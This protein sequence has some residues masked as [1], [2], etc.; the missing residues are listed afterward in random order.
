MKKL[1]VKTKAAKQSDSN[2]TNWLQLLAKK[3]RGKEKLL[4]ADQLKLKTI[5]LSIEQVF[6]LAVKF[7]VR[8]VI[9]ALCAEGLSPDEAIHHLDTESPDHFLYASTAETIQLLIDCGLTRKGVTWQWQH[10][11]VEQG[12]GE[13]LEMVLRLKPAFQCSFTTLLVAAIVANRP[14]IV[15]VLIKNCE[16]VNQPGTPKGSSPLMEACSEGNLAIVTQLL[17]AGA[18]VNYIASGVGANP[19]ALHLV[20][21]TSFS[22]TEPNRLKILRTLLDAGVNTDLTRRNKPTG[23][24]RGETALSY[25]AAAGLKNVVKVLL[26][27][28]A[29]VNAADANGRTPLVEAVQFRH[30]KIIPILLQ[31]GAD[32]NV[33]CKLGGEPKT[34]AKSVLDFCHPESPEYR[35]VRRA[36][37]GNPELKPHASKGASKLST[38]QSW[39]RIAAWL[40]ENDPERLKSLQKP[41]T[42]RE[43]ASTEKSLGVK[44]PEDLKKSYRVHNGQARRSSLIVDNGTFYFL[45]LEEVIREWKIWVDLVASGTFDPVDCRCE[46]GIKSDAWFNKKWIP[47][48]SDGGGDFYCVDMAP[49]KGGRVGQ[50]ILVEHEDGGRTVKASSLRDLL[51]QLANELEAGEIIYD[52]Y[53]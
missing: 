25:A 53:D 17:E 19:T 27:A 6:G 9:A 30:E 21:G 29:D 3:C 2:F 46:D 37:D 8:E 12:M 32:V 45:S 4:F 38:H 14:K 31:Y 34:C 47:V 10:F 11:L 22:G 39:K 42:N 16:D 26:E 36:M 20:C 49:A 5:T 28:G 18:D 23:L 43:I 35:L 51:S 13:A 44:F 40:S 33:R 15:A 7:N 1:R 24:Y 48:F 50:I 52:I 41:A